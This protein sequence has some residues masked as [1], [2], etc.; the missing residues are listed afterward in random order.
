MQRVDCY[1]FWTFE[2]RKIQ[3]DF[4]AHKNAAT[5]ATYTK[6]F[7]VSIFDKSIISSSWAIDLEPP[8]NQ[9]KSQ[10][11]WRQKNVYPILKL[12]LILYKLWII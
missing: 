10:T 9:K 1:F 11:H 4:F 8:R 6:E 2:S 3:R 12:F 5:R 7:L